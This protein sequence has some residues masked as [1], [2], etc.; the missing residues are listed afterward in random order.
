[1]ETGCIGSL[2]RRNQTVKLDHIEI[3]ALNVE[4][5]ALILQTHFGF[6]KD[7]PDSDVLVEGGCRI[8]L[9]KERQGN[10]FVYRFNSRAEAAEK[11]KPLEDAVLK[12]EGVPP[13]NLKKFP[14]GKKLQNEGEHTFQLVC[15]LR[16]RFVW[17]VKS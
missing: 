5:A 15:G 12:P 10:P 14:T 11:F 1:M 2:R 16:F 13:E 3:F 7:G 8:V 6:K 9:S 17:G 4:N